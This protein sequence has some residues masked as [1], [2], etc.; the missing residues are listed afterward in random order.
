LVGRSPLADLRLE[1][2]QVSS[3]HARIAWDRER[4]TLRDLGSSNGTFVNKR[5]LPAGG[6]RVL[7]VGDVIHFATESTPWYVE[8]LAPPLA[9]AVQLGTGER[10]VGTRTLLTV[11]SDALELKIVHR[12]GAW[13]SDNDGQLTEVTSGSIVKLGHAR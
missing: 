13:W 11:G 10:V 3:E 7:A 1:S 12:D 4:W 2:R 9:T 6:A 8:N 5:R